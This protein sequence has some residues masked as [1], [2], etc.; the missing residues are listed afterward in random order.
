LCLVILLPQ[1]PRRRSDYR[2]SVVAMPIDDLVN[3]SL[4]DHKPLR[5]LSLREI[6]VLEKPDHFPS[7]FVRWLVAGSAPEGLFLGLR[8]RNSAPH[9]LP[10]KIMLELRQGRHE[11]RY[12]LALRRREI[13]S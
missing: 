8:R 10:Q 6:L 4:R 3:G 9:S 13:E 5:H 1:S 12:E 2:D 7:V 11:V